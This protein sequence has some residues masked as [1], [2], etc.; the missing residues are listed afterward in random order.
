[1]PEI[2]YKSARG[3]EEIINRRLRNSGGE[4]ADKT[5]KTGDGVRRVYHNI[6]LTG[7]AKQHGPDNKGEGDIYG[8]PRGSANSKG[9]I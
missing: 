6:H 1:M 9:E 5:I 2:K 7:T 8:R 3:P 4:E